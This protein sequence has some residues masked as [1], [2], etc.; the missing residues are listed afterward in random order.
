MSTISDEAT[1]SVLI[2]DPYCS[3]NNNGEPSGHYIHFF[4]DMKNVM[5]KDF[6]VIIACSEEYQKYLSGPFVTVPSNP[7]GDQLEKLSSFSRLSVL[8]IKP[9]TTIRRLL[10]LDVDAIIFQA[11]SLPALLLSILTTSSK[12]TRGKRIFLT[13]YNDQI[14]GKHIKDRTRRL[15]FFLAKKRISGIITGIPDLAEIY[16]IKTLAIPDYFSRT[17]EIITEAKSFFK[18]DIAQLGIVNE[19]KNVEKVAEIFKDTDLKLVIAGRFNSRERYEAFRNSIR[20]YPNISLINKY[21]ADQEYQAILKESRFV[22][23][24]YET[25]KLQ[26]SGVYYE[27]LL[28][29]KPVL[30]SNAPFFKDVTEKGLGYKYDELSSNIGD[31]LRNEDNYQALRKNIYDYISRIQNVSKDRILE[32]F[33][34]IIGN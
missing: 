25:N 16:Q 6:T 9:I 33:T 18:Y 31:F 22:V 10:Q 19:G 15:L 1:P 4:K 17:P 28:N 32:F 29:L 34:E 27:A 13:I 8:N 21:L 14:S 20:D 2:A 12:F 24:P 30:V 11:S 5:E 23:L 7:S 26:S 3:I